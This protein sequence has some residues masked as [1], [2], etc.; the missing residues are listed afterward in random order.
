MGNGGHET[1]RA[2]WVVDECEKGP[3]E[4]PT[5]VSMHRRGRKGGFFLAFN[6]PQKGSDDTILVSPLGLLP[7]AGSLCLQDLTFLL[8]LGV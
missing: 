7:D 4:P 2:L 5:T 8:C 3:F 1:S 6:S